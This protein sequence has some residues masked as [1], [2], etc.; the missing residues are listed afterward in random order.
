MLGLTTGVRAEEPSKGTNDDTGE[1]T[2]TNPIEGKTYS[3]YQL[4]VLESYNTELDAY[5][6]TVA[7]GW[8]N[9][10]NNKDIKEKYIKFDATGK[11]VTWVKD[12]DAVAFSKGF[13]LC[14]RK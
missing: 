8:E 3:L 2:V 7:N 12:A 11:Y 10:F 6:Y 14:K 13:R 5:S 4:L 1:I 9:F